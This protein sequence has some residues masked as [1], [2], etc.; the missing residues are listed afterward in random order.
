MIGRA[1]VKVKRKGVQQ[2]KNKKGKKKERH[3]RRRERYLQRLERKTLA[4]KGDQSHL[5]S[6]GGPGCALPRAPG[7]G[8][9]DEPLVYW[10]IPCILVQ[11]CILQG[12]DTSIKNLYK[13]NHGFAEVQR[14]ALERREIEKQSRCQ[15]K[16]GCWGRGEKSMNK[17]EKEKKRE[18]RNRQDNATVSLQCFSFRQEWS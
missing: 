5:I 16:G 1:E 18:E 2:K 7:V 6:S 13:G 14:K 15:R 3:K 11:A 8:N 12:R 17:K 9:G 10:L 4:W